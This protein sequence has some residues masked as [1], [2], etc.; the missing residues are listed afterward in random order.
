LAAILDDAV[1][2]M[3][4]IIAG[5]IFKLSTADI[6][7]CICILENTWRSRQLM[8]CSKRGVIL[9]VWRRQ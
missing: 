3:N 6:L 2:S 5:S 7:Y 9:T 1:F 8:F 4:E